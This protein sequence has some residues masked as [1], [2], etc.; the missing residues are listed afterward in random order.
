MI[1][2]SL[3]RA[4]TLRAIAMQQ[5]QGNV[6]EVDTSDV[7]MIR[8]ADGNVVEATPNA[9]SAVGINQLTGDVLAGPGA[10]VQA[11][12]AVKASGA[13]AGRYE[14]VNPIAVDTAA[15]HAAAA[16]AVRI[17]NATAIAARN[18]GDGADLNI[19]VT[20]GTPGNDAM[21]IGDTAAVSTTLDAN[22]ILILGGATHPSVRIPQLGGVGTKALQTDNAGNVS[23]GAAVG[24]AGAA[25][26]WQPA[27]VA[28]GNVYTTLE[29]LLTAA[30]NVP[31]PKFMLLD[32]S[33]GGFASFTAAAG[34]HN[35]DQ[36]TIQPI[37]NG[38]TAARVTIVFPAGATC[39]FNYLYCRGVVLQS[40]N[41]TTAVFL[42]TAGATTNLWMEAGGMSTSGAGALPVIQVPNTS[43]LNLKLLYN[44]Q[45]AA[46][47]SPVLQADAGGTITTRC[48]GGVGGGQFTILAS[49]L[50]G[51]GTFNVHQS[52]ETLVSTTQAGITGAFNLIWD[53]IVNQVQ[54]SGNT[55]TGTHTVSATTG[56]IA[57]EKSGKVSVAGSC[58]GA[59]AAAD[60]ITA[61]LVRDL[62]GAAVVLATQTVTTTATQ[63]NYNVAF[64]PWVDTLPDNATHTYSIQLAGAQN[65]TVAANQALVTANEL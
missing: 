25:F 30:A 54:A 15:G 7:V 53:S 41:T 40:Q 28:G 17:P 60:T 51:G 20:S 62:G 31:G 9:A 33:A 65:N 19:V 26:V 11:A 46:G 45:I 3:W 55:G 38:V 52:A 47:A 4:P 58:A 32:D 42:V 14:V 18:A 35:L 49:T 37:Q 6:L 21:L 50:T 23:T 12:T 64:P 61:T 29:T 27:G 39:S 34:A 2:E 1:R 56:N 48:L 36:F 8:T 5:Q 22:A 63:L 44:A 24:G 59:T 57:R 13:I 43:T 16:G 10:G